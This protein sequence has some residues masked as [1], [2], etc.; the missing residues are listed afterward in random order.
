MSEALPIGR[1]VMGLASLTHPTFLCFP[2]IKG[3]WRTVRI[4]PVRPNMLVVA[5]HGASASPYQ[6]RHALHFWRKL[7]P[8]AAFLLPIAP[9]RNAGGRLRRLARAISG[10]HSWFSLDD[11][12]I[13]ALRD[14]SRPVAAALNTLIDRELQR[15]SLTG[16]DLFLV[17]FSQG[18]MLAL[19]A[20]LNRAIAPR[21][22]AAAAAALLES[23]APPNKAPVCLVHGEADVV[24]APGLSR[25]AESTLQ[26]HG[27]DVTA[28]Y[29][30]GVGHT[31]SP[32]MIALIGAFLASQAA[33]Q[34]AWLS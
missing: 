31:L 22:I 34:P 26:E 4:R 23:A 30:P 11:P 10:R 28:H 20:G 29:L 32:E 6:L 24:V 18:G 21:G 33:S 27:L 8:D 12:R 17:G 5:C 15:L 19:S 9:A 7:L 25:A 1:G 16:N 14:A 2:P 13:E 3:I